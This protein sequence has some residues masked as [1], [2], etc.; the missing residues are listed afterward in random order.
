MQPVGFGAQVNPRDPLA[1]TSRPASRRVCK[2]LRVTLG[3]TAAEG[4]RDAEHDQLGEGDPLHKQEGTVRAEN[5]KRALDFTPPVRRQ[6]MRS[7]FDVT[8]VPIGGRDQE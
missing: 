5:T 4:L 1:V 6:E 2:A 7:R 3:A 8:K